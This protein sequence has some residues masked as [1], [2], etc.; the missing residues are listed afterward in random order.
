MIALIDTS[1]LLAFVR[2]YLPF[3]KKG[4]FK[5]L[6]KTKFESGELLVLD[7]V[8]EEAKFISQGIILKELD[9]LNDKSRHINTNSLIPSKKFFNLL[10]N[11]FCNKDLVRLKGVTDVEFE[12]EKTNFLKTPDSNLLL[13]SLSMKDKN[14]IVVTEET[15]SGNDNKVF[16]KIPENCKEVDIDCCT[17]PELLKVHL[18]IDISTLT[19]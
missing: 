16:K 4:T 9:F 3:D 13:Y 18:K 17:L 7:K 2:Y 1:S 8:I 15:K 14:P 19:Q 5:D 10:E 6:I 11:Q 12:L